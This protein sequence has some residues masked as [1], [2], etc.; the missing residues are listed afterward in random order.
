M[1]KNL[2][3]PLQMG[4]YQLPNRIVMAPLTRMRAPEAI[5]TDLMVSYYK[6]RAAAGL[7]VT[8]ATSISP[9]GFGYPNI[10]G[11]F[12]DAHIT[13]WQKITS[14]VH[15]RN[16]RVFLQ[17]W[18]VGRISHPDFHGGELPVAPSAIA[19]KGEAVT[20]S[21]MQP[22]VTPRALATEELPGIVEQYRHAAACAL[23]AGFDGVEIHSANGYLL[24]Q[25][26]R[27][28]TNRRD[29]QYGGSLE[30]RCRLLLE[31]T[32]AV[33]DVWGSERVGVRLSP[34]GTFNDMIDSDPVALFTYVLQQLSSFNLAYLHLV[35][36]LESDIRH[37]AH[38]ADLAALRAAYKGCLIVCGGYDKARGND[39]IA[40]GL[41][42]AVAYGVLYIANPDLVERFKQDAPLN[43]P[44]PSTFYG[45][46]EK[47]YIDYPFLTAD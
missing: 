1:I 37:G 45:G 13:G 31:V 43:T 17:L 7:I 25:F 11:I 22:F 30:N 46:D 41:A 24:D 20:Y 29:D 5:P 34:S 26:L 27:D 10:P 32:Q 9:Q 39:A 21:G 23:A 19:P 12:N 40:A 47:G 8:E 3:S 42:D 6:Q 35:D 14:A 15:E 4:A 38:V 33:V 28:G 36:A 44:D 18:H 16:G 2:F